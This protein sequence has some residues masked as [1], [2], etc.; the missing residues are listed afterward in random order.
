MVLKRRSFLLIPLLVI[1]CSLIGGI[2]G[3]R[4]QAPASAASSDKDI[5]TGL[6]T[7]TDVYDTVDKNFADKVNADKAIF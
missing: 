6:R 7:F 2:Y 3:Q 5:E 4:L 1:A